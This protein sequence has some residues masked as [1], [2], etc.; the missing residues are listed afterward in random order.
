MA[1]R[2]SGFTVVACRAAAPRSLGS[3]RRVTSQSSSTVPT[4]PWHMLPRIHRP[5][6]RRVSSKYMPA[7]GQAPVPSRPTPGPWPYHMLS[8]RA[9]GLYLFPLVCARMERAFCCSCLCSSACSVC[10]SQGGAEHPRRRPSACP[11]AAANTMKHCTPCAGSW[12]HSADD[13]TQ[14]HAFPTSR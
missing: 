5:P 2:F 1:S 11:R 12:K 13:S 3:P 10:L 9:A 14:P 8:V 6:P 7:H 4:A